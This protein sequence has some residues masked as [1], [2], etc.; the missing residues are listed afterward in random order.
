MQVKD[1]RF[2]LG[3]KEIM[4]TRLPV[5]IPFSTSEIFIAVVSRT[6]AIGYRN[7]HPTEAL[8]KTASCKNNVLIERGETVRIP[9]IPGSK[10]ISG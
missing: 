7:S 9:F 4:K 10:N 1:F 8:D 3:V 5:N 2:L 6:H